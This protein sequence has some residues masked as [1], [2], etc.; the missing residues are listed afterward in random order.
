MESSDLEILVANQR[1][2][3]MAASAAESDLDLAFRLQMEEALAA[4]VSLL[5]STSTSV[6]VTPQ[7][8]GGPSAS[9]SDADFAHA[10]S[11]QSFELERCEQELRDADLRR[12]ELRRVTQELRIRAHDEELAR[13]IN[14]MPEDDWEDFGDEFE[15]PMELLRV[16]EELP[17]R[18]YFKGMGRTEIVNGSR[19]H[20]AGIGVAIC[21]PKGDLL[22]KIQKPVPAAGTNREVLDAKALIEGLSAVVEIGIKNVNVYFDF[23]ALL[24][25]VNGKWRAKQQKIVNLISQVHLL[26]R[27]IDRCQLLLLPRCH[28]KFV[29]KLARDVIDSQITKG[30]ELLQS[31]V[32]RNMTETCNICLDITASS[33]MFSVVG[34]DHRFCFSC[35]KQHVEV[36]L[37]HGMLPVCPHLGC[38]IKLD[39]ESCGKFLSPRL[40]DIMGQR[41]KEES[42]P[43]NQKVYC[44]F[45]RC[46]ALM[47]LNEAILPQKSGS[48]KQNFS[49]NSGLRKCIKCDGY[50]CI[51]CKVPWH[52]KLSCYDY[53]RLNPQPRGEEARLHS[54]ARQKLWRQCVKCNHM[55]ELVEGCFHMTCRCGC[56]F[57]YTCGA[58]WKDKRAACAC[59]LWDEN[60]IWYDDEQDSEDDYDDEYDDYDDDDDDDDYD[61]DH[62][63]YH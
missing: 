58:E 17:F 34:C 45:P 10:L 42:I 63:D 31:N 8:E 57:C 4:S 22:L 56:E 51:N 15:V 26:Q 24:N 50:F 59:P 3:F 13:E 2:E 37:L 40:L 53:K 35:M 30:V 14:D 5:P 28:V 21:D 46:S 7:D 12:S 25:H 48:V 61:D 18:L 41:I 16:E 1:R 54:L 52:E 29:F 11:M 62:R 55:I 39:L 38:N 20:I 33:Q 27:K 47:S 19:T 6:A 32:D 44:P 60:Y 49:S 43:P 36:K 9:S 23:R